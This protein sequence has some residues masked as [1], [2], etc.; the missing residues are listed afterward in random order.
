MK[1]PPAL[2]I[3][4][5]SLFA[6]N[7]THEANPYLGIQI[8]QET[9]ATLAYDSPA[10]TILSETINLNLP[11]CNSNQLLDGHEVRK[12][13]IEACQRSNISA[14]DDPKVL[15]EISTAFNKPHQ[16][17]SAST[18]AANFY[19]FI[20]FL[21]QAGDLEA[22]SRAPILRAPLLAGY[23][24]SYD[25]EHVPAVLSCQSPR[26]FS[27]SNATVGKFFDS[28]AQESGMLIDPHIQI[29]MLLDDRIT[30]CD[31][32]ELRSIVDVFSVHLDAV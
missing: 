14:I 3:I 6:A 22:E 18:K 10:R 21:S 28:C 24:C 19:R 17:V 12:S 2:I 29:V 13:P 31:S 15:I 9:I 11:L 32:S 8:E 23:V 4:V 20:G 16:N 30:V 27:Y 26:D 5:P 25:N 1:L 7:C